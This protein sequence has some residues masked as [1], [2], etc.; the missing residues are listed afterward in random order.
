M[1]ATF[2]HTHTIVKPWMWMNYGDR[3]KNHQQ[4]GNKQT[5]KKI[6]QFYHS[7]WMYRLYRITKQNKKCIELRNSGRNSEKKIR[8]KRDDEYPGSSIIQNA[9][10]NKKK[11]FFPIR[12]KSNRPA[13]RWECTSSSYRS[14]TN[15]R[16]ETFAFTK[17]NIQ[18]SLFE[19]SE[20]TIATHTVSWILIPCETTNKQAKQVKLSNFVLVVSQ[21]PGNS[22]AVESFEL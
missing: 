1:V 10:R 3:N 17:F 4:N 22:A 11:I 15:H 6:L 5:R 18:N 20:H 21:D 7:R 8:N 14:L 9:I 12:I 2:T 16:Y 19:S 13:Q